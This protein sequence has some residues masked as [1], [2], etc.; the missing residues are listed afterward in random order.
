MAHYCKKYSTEE[1]EKLS[2]NDYF[3]LMCKEL[4]SAGFKEKRFLN[5]TIEYSDYI[6]SKAVLDGSIIHD[7]SAINYL[8]QIGLLNNGICPQCG[9]KIT[10]QIYTFSDW[11]EPQAS[12]NIC[13]LCYNNGIILQEK[14]SNKNG[15]GCL[16][17]PL[18]W[19][20]SLIGLPF[21]LWLWISFLL[22][23]LLKQLSSGCVIFIIPSL[24]IWPLDVICLFLCSCLTFLS[25]KIRKLTIS[26][27]D[28]MKIVTSQFPKF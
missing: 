26:F 16:V 13:K 20:L 6:P 11:K 23:S 17:L 2:L 12:Y 24:I 1:L 28:A 22:N 18:C 8:K 10:G 25:C 7:I 15:Y 14:Y 21:K 27:A 5:G 3:R 4:A 19:C 9:N